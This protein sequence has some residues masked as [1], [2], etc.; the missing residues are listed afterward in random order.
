MIIE[1]IDEDTE[2]GFSLNK[3]TKDDTFDSTTLILTRFKL[4]SYI[5]EIADFIDKNAI[6]AIQTEQ[7]CERRR[8]MKHQ[9]AQSYSQI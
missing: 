8:T 3:V 7:R 6:Y 2:N 9:S 1:M 4:C 5:I